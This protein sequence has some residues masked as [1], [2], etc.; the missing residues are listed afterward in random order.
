MQTRWAALLANEATN[1]G[2]VHPSFIDILKQLSP[3][4]ARLLDK[5]C[6]KCERNTSRRVRPVNKFSQDYE[7]ESILKPHEDSL[8][9]LV[10]L[11]LMQSEYDLD[12][13]H[14]DQRMPVYLES[15]YELSDYDNKHSINDD[16]DNPMG[17][18]PPRFSL[19][20]VHP[21]TEFEVCT[22]PPCGDSDDGWV[23]LADI[24]LQP[25]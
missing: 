9:N 15:W 11:G 20:E 10:R 16:E 22:T 5:V 4:D 6:D 19:W 12:D 8:E 3:D 2:S 23:K 18:Q 14:A 17:G 13:R 1:I 7:M 21:I 24:N 25:Q